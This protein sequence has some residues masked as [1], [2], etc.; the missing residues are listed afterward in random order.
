MRYVAPPRA[1]HRVP[2]RIMCFAGLPIF[3]PTIADQLL[4]N[5]LLYMVLEVQLQGGTNLA[6]STW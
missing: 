3:G 5:A 4:G 2:Y 1:R 6:R